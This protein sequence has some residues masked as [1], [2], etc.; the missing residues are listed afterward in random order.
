MGLDKVVLIIFR[1]IRFYL[2]E[3]FFNLFVKVFCKSVLI[4]RI[5]ILLIIFLIIRRRIFLVFDIIDFNNN[6]RF[7]KRISIKVFT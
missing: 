2:V 5:L 1:V 6:E 4:K 3:A 7:S